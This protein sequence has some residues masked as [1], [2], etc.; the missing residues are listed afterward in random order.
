MNMNGLLYAS[1]T[2]PPETDPSTRIRLSG[3]QNQSQRD[4]EKKK[5]D[6]PDKNRTPGVHSVTVTSYIND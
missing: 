1:A 6:I 2:L 5:N 3:S 4:S